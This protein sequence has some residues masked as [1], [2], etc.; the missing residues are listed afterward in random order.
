MNRRVPQWTVPAAAGVTLGYLAQ[1]RPSLLR[2]GATP[3][4]AQ[5]TYLG[6]RARY[7]HDT[8]WGFELKD[9]PGGRPRLVVSGFWS[10]RPTLLQPLLSVLLWN[11]HTW[12]CSAVGTR[13]S[14]AGPN[15]KAPERPLFPSS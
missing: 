1:V 2:T 7:C 15:Q 14:N 5:G 11:P 6:E 9:A 12:S 13:I 8:P 10:F 3:E 4:E